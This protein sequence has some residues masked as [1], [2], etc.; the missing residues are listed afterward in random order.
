MSGPTFHPQKSC[1][2]EGGKGSKESKSPW[3]RFTHVI[4]FSPRF[5]PG[6]PQGSLTMTLQYEEDVTLGHVRLGVQGEDAYRQ[7][8]PPKTTS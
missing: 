1:G 5:F 3:L 6:K 7:Y 8:H 2:A 4:V